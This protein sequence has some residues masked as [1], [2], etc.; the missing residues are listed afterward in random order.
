[1]IKTFPHRFHYNKID[2]VYK[3]MKTVIC[4]LINWFGD[5]DRE[6]IN[7]I[8]QVTVKMGEAY[9]RDFFE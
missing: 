7:Y 1:M 2:V 6:V 9:I 3:M 5:I 8:T 4:N